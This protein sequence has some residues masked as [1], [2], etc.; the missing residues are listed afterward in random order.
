[1]TI[2]RL[3]TPP[4]GCSVALYTL[5]NTAIAKGGVVNTLLPTG[6]ND[7]YQTFQNRLL[8]NGM[9]FT[10]KGSYIFK[11][12]TEKPAISLRAIKRSE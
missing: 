9:E 2:S 12:A 5:H 3:F 10:D 6:W 7:T 4:P 8:N 11:E 1:M